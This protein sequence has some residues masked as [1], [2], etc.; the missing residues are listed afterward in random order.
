MLSLH[1]VPALWKTSIVVP[2]PNIS[3]PAIPNDFRP[4]RPIFGVYVACNEEL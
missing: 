3:R 1:K 4:F 2:V